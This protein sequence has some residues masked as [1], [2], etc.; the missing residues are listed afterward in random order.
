MSYENL[1]Q[2][3]QQ[4]FGNYA[5]PFRKVNS[6]M[7]EHWEKM[8]DYQLDMVRRYT[9]VALGQMR[10]AADLQSPEQ[11]Q[12]Y[13]QKSSEAVR[14]TSDSLAK[15]ARTLTEMGQSMTQ[16]V[17]A[18]MRENLAGLAPAAAGGKTGGSRKAA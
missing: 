11:M 5:E 17:Q 2:Q 4:Q 13:L 16:D 12:S 18:A 7:L 14:E 3:M 6:K 8:A 15:D 9:D 10:E 1:M